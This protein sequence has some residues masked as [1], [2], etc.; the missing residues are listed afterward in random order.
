MANIS[1]CCCVV[2]KLCL[3][4]FAVAKV[5]SIAKARNNVLVF[6]QA[7]VDCTAP[8]GSLVVGESLFNVVDTFWR[9]YHTSYV[10]VARCTFREYRLVAK[11][12]RTT[13]CQHWVGNNEGF[14]VDIR[15]CQI[16]YV[17]AYFVVFLFPVCAYESIACMVENIEKSVVERKSCTKDSSKHNLVSRYVYL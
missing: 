11:L 4:F 7:F 12:H 5:S 16:F 8:N 10:D 17:N 2:C 14:A 15:C 1:H 3:E 6:V 9:S 13:C